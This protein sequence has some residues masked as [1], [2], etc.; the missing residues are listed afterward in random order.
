M[1]WMTV[2]CANSV[3]SEVWLILSVVVVVLW[4]AAIAGA[5][6]LLGASPW[7]RRSERP[8][9]PQESVGT[10]APVRTDR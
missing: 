1:R 6:A 3:G 9:S 5:M 8:D 10:A 2:V 7:P 4:A